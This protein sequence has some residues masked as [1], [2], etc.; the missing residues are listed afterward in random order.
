MIKVNLNVLKPIKHCGINPTL[1]DKSKA[2]GGVSI[3]CMGK[4]CFIES[5]GVE[6]QHAN[7]I[8]ENLP[9]MIIALAPNLE[10]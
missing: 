8:W 4:S 3:L 9:R 5:T 10:L 6:V 1:K 7:Q 2:S